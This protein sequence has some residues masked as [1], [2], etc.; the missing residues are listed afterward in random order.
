[1]NA[2]RRKGGCYDC[3]AYSD[4]EDIDPEQVRRRLLSHERER[5]EITGRLTPLSNGLLSTLGSWSQRCKARYAVERLDE[6]IQELT[7]IHRTSPTRCLRCWSAP[8]S[9]VT[10]DPSD[11]VSHDFVYKCGGML[12]RGRKPASEG[13][14]FLQSILRSIYIRRLELGVVSYVRGPVYV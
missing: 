6:K 11:N 7:E 12:K 3:D 1:M 9:P 8:T 14:S 5:A 10:F 4:I 13:F 2:G